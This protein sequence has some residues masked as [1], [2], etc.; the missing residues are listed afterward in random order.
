MTL[1]EVFLQLTGAEQVEVVAD[2]PAELVAE[3]AQA[4]K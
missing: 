4:S 1:E 3:E 2:A